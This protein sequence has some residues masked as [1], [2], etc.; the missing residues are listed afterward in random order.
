MPIN[1]AL[2]RQKQEDHCR[3]EASLRYRVRPRPVIAKQQDPAPKD[4]E[5]WDV[6][7]YILF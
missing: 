3:V 6:L 2:E 5:H 4:E 7:K 1:S